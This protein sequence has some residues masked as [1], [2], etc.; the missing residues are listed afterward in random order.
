LRS[1]LIYMDIR[2]DLQQKIS[3]QKRIQRALIQRMP[4]SLIRLGD[5]EGYLFSDR[6]QYFKLEDVQNRERHW[7][8]EELPNSLRVDI[9]Q[10]GRAAL[11]TADVVGI[12]SVHR[13]IRDTSDRTVSMTASIQGR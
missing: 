4:F 12:P 13:F 2:T 10:Q 9:I 1:R 7:W 3:I 8:G 11:K 6:A 5:G